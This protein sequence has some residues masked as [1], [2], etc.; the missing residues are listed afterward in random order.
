MV[1]EVVVGLGEIEKEFS[2]ES[3]PEAS[4]RRFS[5]F[6]KENAAFADCELDD[7]V[8]KGFGLCEP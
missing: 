3:H 6:N 8:K 1:K 5:V 4:Q 2:F 7:K